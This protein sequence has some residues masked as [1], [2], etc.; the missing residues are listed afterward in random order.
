MRRNIA[1]IL[2][3]VFGLLFSVGCSKTQ[4]TTLLAE[5]WETGQHRSCLF[6]HKN[7]YCFP[8]DFL[9]KLPE[10]QRKQATP[11]FMEMKR[12]TLLEDKRSDGGSYETRFISHTPM[13]FST[14]DCY[15]TGTGSP[16]IVC[17]LKHKP[18]KEESA[19]FVKSEKE[20]EDAV[21]AEKT[22]KA[23]LHRLGPSAT[24]YLHSL[25]PED[26]VAACGSVREVRNVE[27]LFK[28][29]KSE[30]ASYGLYPR[31]KSLTFIR[32]PFADFNWVM[33]SLSTVS[34][35]YPN[36]SWYSTQSTNDDAA[37]A[38]QAIPCLFSHVAEGESKLAAQL[39]A[40]EKAQKAQE[41]AR[42]AQ[43]AQTA[44]KK[45]ECAALVLQANKLQNGSAEWAAINNKIAAV[46]GDDY[47]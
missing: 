25:T 1:L 45:K 11:Y 22:R 26:V 12:E 43:E 36:P 9:E 2:A 44:A 40:Q 29:A 31:N 6:G 18:T 23:D 39:Q 28:V 33:S 24:A 3:A 41:E 34:S 17:D 13:D 27:Q 21:V 32:Y 37:G 19:A 16:A 35:E 5:Q 42:K 47:L 10:E 4:T 38:L 15:K 20:Q 7:L 14:W 46:C 30:G 8:A